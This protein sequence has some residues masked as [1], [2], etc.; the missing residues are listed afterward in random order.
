MRL[1][2]ALTPLALAALLASGAAQAAGTDSVTVSITGTVQSA[3]CKF[4]ASTASV[5]FDQITNAALVGGSVAAKELTLNITE[6]TLG[7]S[8]EGGTWAAS[9]VQVT[10]TD[11]NAGQGTGAGVKIG[12]QKSSEIYLEVQDKSG[13]AIP[14]TTG[15]ATTDLSK[16]VNGYVS[17]AAKIKLAP[18]LVGSTLTGSGN[19]TAELTIAINQQ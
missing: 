10:I 12:A 16:L 6:C 8:A 2:N 19:L 17:P 13:S 7:D 18:K 1:S 4:E 3:A 15:V 5:A 9:S 14:M 11:T